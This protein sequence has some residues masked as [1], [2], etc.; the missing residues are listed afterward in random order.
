MKTKFF[1]IALA[2]VGLAIILYFQTST[3]LAITTINPLC[4]GLP[5]TIWADHFLDGGQLCDTEGEDHGGTSGADGVDAM[6]FDD[7]CDLDI[8]TGWE[9]SGRVFIYLNPTLTARPATGCPTRYYPDN[10]Q[11]RTN[12]I[13]QQWPLIEVPGLDNNPN[14]P[15]SKVED[16]IFA[17]NDGD[18][19]ADYVVIATEHDYIK[20]EGR[21]ETFVSFPTPQNNS[22]VW[23]TFKLKSSPEYFMRVVVGDIDQLGC[24]DILSG[25][26]TI[27]LTDLFGNV[28]Y[29]ALG[30]PVTVET[31]E[32]YWWTC[33]SAWSP[34][35]WKAGMSLPDYGNKTEEEFFNDLWEERHMIEGDIEWIMEMN[36][37]NLVPGFNPGST[38]DYPEILFTD[39]RKVGYLYL[40]NPN[41]INGEDGWRYVNIDNPPGDGTPFRWYRL[42]QL[43]DSDHDNNFALDDPDD[44]PEIVVA[45][46]G[47]QGRGVFARWYERGA[48]ETITLGGETITVNSWA[49]YE[50]VLED[51]IIPWGDDVSGNSSARENKAAGIADVDGDGHPEIIATIRGGNFAGTFYLK[52]ETGLEPFRCGVGACSDMQEWLIGRISPHYTDNIKFDNLVLI[53]ADFDCD[54]DVFSVEENG[55]G[56]KGLGVV[57]YENPLPQGSANV[58]CTAPVLNDDPILG[59][60][61]A[62]VTVNEGSEA[63]NSGTFSDSDGDQV[64]ITASIGTVTINN[65]TWHWQYPATDG[66]ALN[67]QVTLIADDDRGGSAT[68]SFILNVNN[69]APLITSIS[70]NGP[71]YEG[72][73]V[74]VTVNASD[75]AGANDPL[76]YKFD[77]DGDGSYEIGPQ[78]SN[79]AHC[80]FANSGIIQVN[81]L[82]TDGD[83]GQAGDSTIVTVNNASPTVFTPVV[84]PVFGGAN[85]EGKAYNAGITFT[86]PGVDD[87]FTCTVDYG[88]GS[89]VKSGTIRLVNPTDPTTHICIGPPHVYADNG[90]YPVTMII[91]DGDVS[92][93]R[94]TSITVNNVAPSVAEPTIGS[95]PADVNEPVTVVASFD[96]PAGAVDAPYSC[97]VDYGSGAQTGTI[98]NQKCTGPT[99]LYSTEG[100]YAVTVVVTDKDDGS[101]SRTTTV[102]V[103]NLPPVVSIPVISPV[104]SKEGSSVS[105]SASFSDGGANGP[106]TCTVN[107]GDGSGT[108]AGTIAGNT[109]NGSTYIYDDNGSYSVT[110]KVT[111][112]DGVTGNATKAHEVINVAPTAVFT[113]APAEIFIGE[114]TTASFSNFFDPSRADTQAGFTYS[115]DCDNDGAW[116]GS[117]HLMNSFSCQFIPSGT[118]TMAGQISDKDGGATSYMAIVVV[119]TPQQALQTLIQD[120]NALLAAGVL[121]QGQANSLNSKLQNAIANLD[122]GNTIAA[123]NEIEAFRNQLAAFV[124][125]RILTSEQGQALDHKA[126][127]I[128]TAIAFLE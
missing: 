68:L 20:D 99:H 114:W 30:E 29:N 106:Y 47:D 105:V 107:Y 111:D 120:V 58:A 119:L 39:R 42:D 87:N 51:G 93:T 27:Y 104:P 125:E 9:E 32:I 53:D 25:S 57:W 75:P 65:S 72:S 26:K 109:C 21:S 115:Y 13:A 108:H 62:T 94:Q 67:Q 100:D 97:T 22:W 96:D 43:V 128:I 18:G 127:R 101:G 78:A 11:L 5:T 15:F 33:P 37:V 82:V 19:V 116:D 17:D 4:Y 16:A 90:T 31:G 38:V 34:E 102:T 103:I 36:I 50:V 54:V 98:N 10:T 48:P 61:L 74:T 60:A 45:Y 66:P 83:G 56:N 117:G 6:D 73:S 64:G 28:I 7:D 23:H 44:A 8:I 124:S 49:I 24:P 40:V 2:L 59:G 121:N 84:V 118:F 70:N 76:K 79:T 69:V 71:I 126:Q 3:A 92:V 80:V 81:T 122:A 112:K 1:L 123:V 86:D 63:T 14:L 91:G 88:D 77:C 95:S 55:V 35:D 89:S 85:D 113:L 52:P 110:I 46:G 41:N 12:A